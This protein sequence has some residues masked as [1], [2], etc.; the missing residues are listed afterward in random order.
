LLVVAVAVVST[1]EVA[2]VVVVLTQE[3][4]LPLRQVRSRKLLLERVG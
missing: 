3:R 1:Q 2:A 4:R